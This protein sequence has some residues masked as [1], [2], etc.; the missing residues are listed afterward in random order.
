MMDA[1][2]VDSL[3]SRNCRH[4]HDAMVPDI[5]LGS[6]SESGIPETWRS[7][8]QIRENAMTPVVHEIWS[9]RGCT[10]RTGLGALSRRIDD[11]C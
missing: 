9:H 2:G 7:I 1:R 10:A 6:S 4:Y 8:S 5:D 3:P 11:V